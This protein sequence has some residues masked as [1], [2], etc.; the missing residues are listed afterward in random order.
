MTTRTRRAYLHAVDDDGRTWRLVWHPASETLTGRPKHSRTTYTIPARTLLD[1]M[2]T[3]S[4]TQSTPRED[5]R[6]LTFA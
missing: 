4:Q 2:L 6:Q 3:G 5:P 1:A